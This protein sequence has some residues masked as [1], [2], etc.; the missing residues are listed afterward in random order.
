[1]NNRL[2]LATLIVLVP[3]LVH[4]QRLTRDFSVR[5]KYLN[6][7]I[8][9]HED[10]QLVRFVT[11]RDTLS[12]SVIRVADGRP[13]YW[14]FRDV[15][16]LR[17]KT[18]T[19]VFLNRVS[20]IDS[21]HQSDSFPGEDSLY[22]E[23][24]R[25][26]FH[27]SSRRGWNNDPN[28]LVYHDGE[29]HMFYQHNPY[30][31]QWENMH[32]G[33]AVSTDLLHWTELGDVLAPDTLG[34]IFSGSAVTDHTN[35]AGWG[36]D[37]LVA[38]YTSDGRA[39]T[40]CA[41][42]S[43]DNGRSFTK[44]RANPII[45]S[46]R[47]S[48]R[49][50]RDPKV[51][52][53]APNREWVMVLYEEAGISFFTSKNLTRWTYQSHINGFYEC[54]ELFPLPV[55]NEPG[56]SYWV[57]TAGSGTYLLGD[58]NGRVFTPKHGKYRTLY[59]KQ[60]ASQT[61]NQMPDGRRIMIGW[62]QVNAAGMPFNQ[63]MCFPTE[64]TLRNTDEGVRLFMLPI[65]DIGRLHG[66]AHDLSGL[67]VDEANRTLSGI[68]G[69]L[70]HVVARIETATGSRISFDFRGNRIADLDG[71]EINGIQCPQP[72]PGTLVFDA[73]FLI[74][75]TS[76]ESYFHQGRIVFVSQLNPPRDTTGLAISGPARI[77]TLK[78]YEVSPIWNEA[79][80]RR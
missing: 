3:M 76:V 66:A 17:G 31:A 77:H 6:I 35:S 69:D 43:L 22:R 23:S 58:F 80:I 7:P 12:S 28:G 21:I 16:D 51:F 10:R 19:L 49:D 1:M 27:F 11:G 73:E 34:A 14:V 75:R 40:Q 15:S 54:P 47:F 74:D 26:Q 13:D 65:K 55:E 72:R 64:L 70:L 45:R 52:W 4:G 39:E 57:L 50:S 79:D 36:N 67:T 53:Y 18:L 48:S 41:A 37:A 32:W 9:I 25:P 38:L 33:H 5:Q 60:Y 78:V 63:M 59:G 24:H 29:Y 8:A 44:Y 2:A 71:D 20:G 42:Y 68:P 61:Y 46:D 30:E 62:G 56:T